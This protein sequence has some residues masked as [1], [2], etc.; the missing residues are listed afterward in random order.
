MGPVY[1]DRLQLAPNTIVGVRLSDDGRRVFIVAHRYG[2]PVRL[3]ALDSADGRQIADL[4]LHQGVV[5]AFAPSPDGSEVFLVADYGAWAGVV[6][7]PGG[8]LRQV[9]RTQPGTG[10]RF[11]PPVSLVSVGGGAFLTRGYFL[12]GG[13]TRG[14]FLVSFEPDGAGGFRIERRVDL[15]ALLGRSN[16]QDGQLVGVSVS[17]DYSRAVWVV[18]TSPEVS[19]VFAGAVG[20]LEPVQP[21]DQAALVGG[22]A[23]TDDGRSA[24]YGAV[25]RS[26]QGQLRHL[27]LATGQV[28]TLEQG[29]FT[30]PAL[31]PD[32][33]RLLVGRVTDTPPAQEMLYA[34]QSLGW[35]LQPLELARWNRELSLYV[36]ARDGHTFVVWSKE[37]IACGFLP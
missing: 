18:A 31:A 21:V 2:A 36:L 7:I 12:E 30:P 35:K 24:F 27:E 9:F 13:A 19:S 23:L 5:T 22:L 37:R 34:R 17:R 28:K 16:L 25:L 8:R 11:L 10:F 32:G 4:D 6:E 33:S 26:G 3:L 1:L 14:D 29:L 15:G 20:D